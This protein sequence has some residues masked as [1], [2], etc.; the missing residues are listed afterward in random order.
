[1]DRFTATSDKKTAA[2]RP[3]PGESG[4]AIGIR[5]ALVRGRSP[6][7]SAWRSEFGGLGPATAIW[8][9]RPG[10]CSPVA[11]AWR[12]EFG[13]SAGD[14]KIR[15]S[16]PGDRNR[17]LGPATATSGSLGGLDLAATLGP[18][19][20]T[21]RSRLHARLSFMINVLPR[22]ENI[23]HKCELGV[24]ANKCAGKACWQT[25]AP[26]NRCAGGRCWE[27][28][29]AGKPSARNVGS[30]GTSSAGTKC[31]KRVWEL[32]VVGVVASNGCT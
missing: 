23:Y 29:G 12:S 22:R 21:W 30:A 3:Q 17:R 15:R 5:R 13:G 8:R 26:G 18:V 11:S 25:S 28:W 7:A 2:R 20:W 10:D 16:R 1:M 32:G 31:G 24:L 9:S 27:L 4:P 14:C 6:A 19:A